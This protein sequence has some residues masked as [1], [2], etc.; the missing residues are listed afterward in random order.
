VTGQ[1][2][3][4][5]SEFIYGINPV[6]EALKAGR[7]REL[8]ISSSRKKELNE[9]LQLSKELNIPLRIVEERFF[10]SRFPKGHQ[11]I[12]ALVRKKRLTDTAGLLKKV[13]DR[14]S[15]LFLLLDEVEDTRNFGAILRVAEA[16]GVDGVII[17]RRRQAGITPDVVK[18]SAGAFEY[19]DIAEENNIKYAIN[20]LKEEGF[21]LIAL[22]AEGEKLLWD[23]ELRGRIGLIIGS[24][25]R[26][27]R[28]TVL[29]LADEIIKIPMLG[30]V[31]SLNVSV[32]AGIAIYEVLRQKTG[33]SHES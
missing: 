23:V 6:K 8:Y 18:A 14:S 10:S 19:V 27:I 29:R 13:S 15:C 26:G 17:Q 9:I 5:D 3:R 12:G 11:S 33:K 31:N 16:G 2:G 28:E 22:E 32:A 1:N 20:L 25:G 4:S 21:R 24:E 7:V 30:K